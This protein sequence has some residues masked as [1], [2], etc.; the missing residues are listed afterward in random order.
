MTLRSV[1]AQQ[2]QAVIRA[3]ESP[4]RPTEKS[5]P[6]PHRI[7][8]VTIRSCSPAAPMPGLL[9]TS[10]QFR[11]RPEQPPWIKPQPNN[12]TPRSRSAKPNMNNQHETRPEK[13]YR[14]RMALNEALRGVA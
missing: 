7:A 4:A 9:N 6:F 1:L 3:P 2:G 5:F 12:A 11:P 8:S 13:R 10:R 14:T